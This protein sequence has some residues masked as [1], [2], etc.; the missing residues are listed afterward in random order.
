MAVEEMPVRKPVKRSRAAQIFLVLVL[1]SVLS[2]AARIVI[3]FSQDAANHDSHGLQLD[4]LLTSVTAGI[5][6]LVV[7]GIALGLIP[8]EHRLNALRARF[9]ASVVVTGRWNAEFGEYVLANYLPG[10]RRPNQARGIAFTVVGDSSGIQIWGGVRAP[11]QL[12]ILRWSD[13]DRVLM[14]SRAIS[15][16]RTVSTVDVQ[17]KTKSDALQFALGSG[18]WAGAFPAGDDAVSV[19]VD[20]LAAL[21]RDSTN[22]PER[23]LG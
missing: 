22:T 14:G 13:I 17:L 1:I 5:I 2:S 11:R 9:P 18:G 12:A 3:D 7:C 4:V 10:L 19:V 16:I 21:H 6:I 23:T 8:G 15:A 20:E